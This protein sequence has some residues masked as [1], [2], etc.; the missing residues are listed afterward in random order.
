MLADTFIKKRESTPQIT[1]QRHDQTQLALSQQTELTKQSQIL[2]RAGATP[3]PTK[4]TL[5]TTTTQL[6]SLQRTTTRLEKY[7]KKYGAATATQLITAIER[8]KPTPKISIL[9][10]RTTTDLVREQVI[11][12]L[13][14][15]KLETQRATYLGQV[16]EVLRQKNNAEEALE[17]LKQLNA[18][19][20]IK[21][22][23]RALKQQKRATQQARPTQTPALTPQRRPSAVPQRQAPPTQKPPTYTPPTPTPAQLAREHARQI[24]LGARQITLGLRPVPTPPLRMHE[25]AS[26]QARQLA[27]RHQRGTIATPQTPARPTPMRPPTPQEYARERERQQGQGKVL[28]QARFIGYAE[29]GNEM[30]FFSTITELQ[31]TVLSTCATQ[32]I[33]GT[34]IT[35]KAKNNGMMIICGKQQKQTN[36]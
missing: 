33:L 12:G 10:Q 29:P 36:T 17:N 13:K 26:R 3:Q 18:R 28:K 9:R 21:E 23:R 19:R 22:E 27:A 20:K 6:K 11:A 25:N 32:S 1:R 15:R 34:T 16:N 31:P 8:V 4:P 24:T 30:I 7:I 2:T 35:A 14:K 5:I